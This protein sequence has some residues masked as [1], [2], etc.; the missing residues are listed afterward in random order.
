MRSKTPWILIVAVA[1]AGIGALMIPR[2]AAVQ[3]ALA[4]T[5][6]TGK[7]AP[8]FRLTDQFGHG[9]SL[10]QFHGRTVI[11]TFM[12][13][14]C[15]QLCPRV[16]DKLH[17]L[18][19]GLGSGRQRVA[20]LVVSTDPEGDTRTAVQQ[21]SIQHG[22]LYTWH[23]LMGSRN[24]LTP[25]WHAYYIYAAPKGSPS[26]L[27][28]QHTSATYLIDNQGRER[29]LM[30]GDLDAAILDRDIRIL[31]GLPTSPDMAVPAPQAGHPAPALTL[32]TLDGSTVSLA[33]LRGKTVLIN[34]WATW[35]KPCRSEM[36]RL[37]GW[38]RQL[39]GSGLVVLGVDQQED[40]TAVAAFTRKLHIPY[41]IVL[42]GSGDV[43][44]RYDVAFLPTS[45]LIDPEGVVSSVKQGILD[46]SYLTLHVRPLLAARGS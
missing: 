26:T 4:G 21:F 19:T 25:I 41:P 29:V 16:A 9:V 30:G 42:D 1:L 34:F 33:S 28:A 22:M 45:L 37:A 5:I 43:S 27:D 13:A 8:A 23:Y 38:Y 14:H 32:R 17:R 36:P 44:A 12:Y 20:I 10:S 18:V 11:L 46:Q 7:Q 24:R 31:S 6:L 39:R 2:A 3:P 35:C 15:D 40:R